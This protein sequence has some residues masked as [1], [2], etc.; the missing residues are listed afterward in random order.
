MQRSMIGDQEKT[1]PNKEIL[2]W[3]KISWRTKE[4]Q[5]QK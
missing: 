3:D 1:F 4:M 2:Y 5:I